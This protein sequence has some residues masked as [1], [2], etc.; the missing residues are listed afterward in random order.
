[1]LIT[2]VLLFLR[3]K[4]LQSPIYLMSH[5]LVCD[6]SGVLF[7]AI[8]LVATLFGLFYT[9]YFMQTSKTESGEYYALILF[10]LTGFGI[11]VMSADLL[12]AFVGLETLSLSVYILVGSNRKST[13]SLEASVKYFLMG[14]FFAAVFLYGMALV[15]GAT[16]S[17]GFVV[18]REGLGVFWKKPL[19][20]IGISLILCSMLFKASFVP[21][22]MWT[23]D[24]YEGSPLP[25]MGFM[26]SAV[27]LAVFGFLVRWYVDGFCNGVRFVQTDFGW[28]LFWIAALSILLGNLMA[29]R[30]SKIKRM[31]AYSSVA[32]AGYFLVGLM[33][34]SNSALYI[35]LYFYLIV[36]ALSSVGLIGSLVLLFDDHRKESFELADLQQAA[37][38]R[39]WVAVA[40]SVF[41]LSVAGFPPLAGFMGKFYLFRMAFSVP[42]LVGL[43]WIAF[44]G[45]V[46]GAAY[47][48]KIIASM[49]FFD[50][51][52][53]HQ[54]HL[55]AEHQK[56][57][58]DVSTGTIT[59][60]GYA[61]GYA[62]VGL[63][64]LVLF[65][66]ACGLY[67]QF[68]HQ[69]LTYFMTIK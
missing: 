21:F 33:A 35:E 8:A 61:P 19:F 2:L 25:V 29:L 17:T 15:Y 58:H 69:W 41:L 65:V 66:I 43:V 47:Y 26:M 5:M 49:F 20:L 23:P 24:A 11:F 52:H 4:S 67:P 30:Q 62:I 36:Y 18:I 54:N 48:L 56:N 60:P 53:A 16:G 39:P 22:H 32:H 59:V 45:S 31:L 34:L 10:A 44:L 3:I 57:S 40:F 6:R 27:K 1:L 14:A 55:S 7:L 42:Q 46:I 64:L 9:P 51:Q 68:L 37:K 13:S 50:E 28:A 63:G 38:K 12:A